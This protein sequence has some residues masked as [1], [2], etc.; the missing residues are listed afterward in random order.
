[1]IFS[2]TWCFSSNDIIQLDEMFV[3]GYRTNDTFV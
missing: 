3:N 2:V 1:M